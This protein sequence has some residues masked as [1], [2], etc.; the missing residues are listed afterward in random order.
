MLTTSEKLD[1]GVALLEN[2]NINQLAVVLIATQLY[3]V[4][5]AM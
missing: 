3:L 2:A 5:N 4:Y 1:T